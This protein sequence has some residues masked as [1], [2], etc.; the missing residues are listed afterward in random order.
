MRDLN[1]ASDGA[2][3]LLSEHFAGKKVEMVRR[4]REGPMHRCYW[5]VAR[6]VS[7]A[8]G[9]AVWGWALRELPGRFVEAQHHAVWER[10]DGSLSDP[11]EAWEG[12]G[13]TC[14]FIAEGSADPNML[15]PNVPSRFIQLDN[16]IDTKRWI[17][18]N[19]LRSRLGREIADE[20]RK[21][22]HRQTHEGIELLGPQSTRLVNLA[23]RM[24]K[25]E[26]WLR[27]LGETL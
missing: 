8:G 23:N 25:L 2:K 14:R 12:A 20:I 16:S 19:L 9:R 5:N 4:S 7:E 1:L 6:K 11:T 15:D 10:P 18:G 21:L 13:P 22:P 27:P 26:S 24:R 3:A 17:D